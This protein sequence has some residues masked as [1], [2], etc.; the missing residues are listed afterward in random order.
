MPKYKD[1]FYY[2]YL[3]I[4]YPY[5]FSLLAKPV[6][7]INDQWK[8]QRRIRLFFFYIVLWTLTSKVTQHPIQHNKNVTVPSKKFVSKQFA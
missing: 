6:E 1:V 5:Q 4:Y 2:F 7:H 8:D 3:F